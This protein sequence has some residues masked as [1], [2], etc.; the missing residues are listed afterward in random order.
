VSIWAARRQNKTTQGPIT[1]VFD[2]DGV[3]TSGQAFTQTI[4]W[5]GIRGVRRLNRFLF[6]FIAPARAYCIPLR[7]LTHPEDLDGLLSMAAERGCPMSNPRANET[8]Q[9]TPG[10][11]LACNRT[12]LTRRGC[13]RR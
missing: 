1:Y 11:R 8:R 3:H 7:D 12:P 13:A 10:A 5:S 9:P 2:S 4:K 6:V